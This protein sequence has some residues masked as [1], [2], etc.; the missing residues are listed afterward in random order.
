MASMS[1]RGIAAPRRRWGRG[2]DRVTAVAIPL[3]LV[4]LGAL[5]GSATTD[6]AMDWYRGL[7]RPWF[8]PPG[9]AF[10]I[11]WTIL[12][13][14]MGI[15]FWRIIRIAP[16]SAHKIWHRPA[17]GLFCVQLV[18]NLAWNPAFFGLQSPFI[19]VVLILPLLGLIALTLAAF[20]AVDRP[21]ALLLVPYLA[22]VSY[23]TVLAVTIFLMN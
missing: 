5:A 18:L 21:A 11:A 10:G 1:A 3:T 7:D 14:L 13:A 8:T 22:W 17:I 20:W 4:L 16:G 2:V 9:A 19:G 12:Y 6:A 23:A 15:A